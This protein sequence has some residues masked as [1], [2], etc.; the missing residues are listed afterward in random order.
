MTKL[1]YCASKLSR[2]MESTNFLARESS[3]AVMKLKSL[4]PSDD[5][6]DP[7]TLQNYLGVSTDM[8]IVQPM[9]PKQS[10]RT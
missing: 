1:A 8:Y 2:E 6:D 7:L 3:A 5:S 9:I 10:R 4:H